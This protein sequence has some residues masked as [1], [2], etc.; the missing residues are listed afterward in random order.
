MPT[1]RPAKLREQPDDG[2]LDK[3]VFGAGAGHEIYHV[4]N[5]GDRREPIFKDDQDRMLFFETLGQSCLKNG[6]AGAGVVF[7]GQ[8]LSLGGGNAQGQSD[9]GDEVVFGDL[10]GTVQPAAQVGMTSSAIAELACRAKAQRRRK[11]PS[12]VACS[13]LFADIVSISSLKFVGRI[14]L[15]DA[16]LFSCRLSPSPELNLD[17]SNQTADASLA[18]PLVRS[19]RE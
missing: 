13:D 19:L 4:M 9:A 6:L 5:R 10:P 18:L 2:L 12:R 17:A 15:V 1:R 8:S 7:D 3:L 16:P 11:Q 14:L